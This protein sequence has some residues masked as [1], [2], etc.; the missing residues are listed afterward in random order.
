MSVASSSGRRRRSLQGLALALVAVSLLIPFWSVSALAQTSG[1]PGDAP[2]EPAQPVDP[3]AVAAP[4]GGS[5]PAPDDEVVVLVERIKR[6]PGSIHV[7]GQETLE[8]YKYDDPHATLQLVP[9]VYVRQEDGFG[10]RPNIGIRGAISDRS[11]KVALMEDGVLFGP[12]PYSAPAA[13]YFPI[14]SRMTGLEVIKG[15][16]AIKYGPQTVGGAIDVTTRPL[17]ARQTGGLDVSIGQYAYGKLH[18]WFGTNDGVNAFLIEGI[19]LRTDGFKELPSGDETGFYRNELM[20]KAAH[21]FAPGAD[22]H[23]RLSL[24]VTYSEEQSDETYLGLSDADFRA[25]PLRRYA[26]S[27]QDRM[28]WHRTSAVLTHELEPL[29]GLSITTQAYRHDLSRRWSKA[30]H[31]G[32]AGLFDALTDPAPENDPFRAVLEG[33]ADSAS[34]AQQLYVGPNQRDFV[35]QGVQ[36]RAEATGQTGPLS[37]RAE[38]GLRFH[39]DRIERL[40]TENIFDLVGGD[41][42]A[43]DTATLTTTDNEAETYAVAGYVR[44]EVSWRGLTLTP[45]VR[46][47]AF[48]SRLEDDL[49]GTDSSRT[50]VV[51]LPGIGAYYALSDQLGVLAGVHRGMSPPP[52]GTDSKAEISVNYEAGVRY[53]SG[54]RRAEV[55]GYYNAYANLTAI[56]TLSSGCEDQN[57]DRQFEAGRARI[58]GLE[59]LAEDELRFS[60]FRVPFAA[61]YTLTLTEFLETFSSQDPIFGEVEAGDE[62]PYVPKHE[63]RA[64]LG[65]ELERAGGYVAANYVSRMRE[66]SGSGPI[67]LTVATDA[68]FT[69]DVGL[70]YQLLPALRLYA[71]ARNLFD[72]LVIASRRPYGARPNPPRW[73][74][75]GAQLEF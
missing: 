7:I 62:L 25:N 22:R 61:S 35:S 34:A 15:P 16:A 6:V 48:H 70:H 57:L 36:S 59:A 55:I 73:I 42:V 33:T 45:G 46:V 51:P 23:Q 37:H 2:A 24:K 12:A 58:Y 28:K 66:L 54:P 11:S 53:A 49:A 10:L 29:D 67:E 3:E 69:V 27:D 68:Q 5:E 8:R 13:Y 4:E 41:L 17:P 30:N 52:A 26:A 50:L 72:E 65:V 63:G 74:Q 14:I 75:V 20:V 56:C 31:F 1:V 47:E 9:G 32:G 43:T 44:D 64:S 38:A 40:H 39:Y 71:Q 60:G 18:G 19:H 21:D